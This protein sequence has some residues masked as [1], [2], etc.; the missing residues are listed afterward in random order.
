MSPYSS[1]EKAP[2]DA[3]ASHTEAQF[4]KL[5]DVISRSQQSYRELI[6]NLDHAVFTLSLDGEIRVANRRLSEILD[7]S[8]QNLIGR[9]VA[10]FIELPAPTE[11]ERWLP[12][13]L[14]NGSW[15]GTVP[16]RLK[17][18]NELRYF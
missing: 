1:K 12:V 15:T 9:R 16:L 7:V 17:K 2:Q 11:P 10:E 3:P 18:D 5:V 14:K 13:L 8:F 4:D 6:D